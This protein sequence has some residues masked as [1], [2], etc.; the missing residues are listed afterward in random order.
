M[1][2]RLWFTLVV[3]PS[4]FLGRAYWYQASMAES[5]LRSPVLESLCFPVRTTQSPLTSPSSFAHITFSFFLTDG[6]STD[7]KIRKSSNFAGFREISNV[8]SKISLPE[9]RKSALSRRDK[10]SRRYEN[11]SEVDITFKADSTFKCTLVLRMVF[12]VQ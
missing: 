11:I 12:R 4:R 10:T 7:I 6:I 2:L 1:Q 3:S 8:V 5:N 9:S